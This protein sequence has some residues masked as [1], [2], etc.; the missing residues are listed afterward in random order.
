[1]KQMPGASV[2][3]RLIAKACIA[4]R[5]GNVINLPDYDCKLCSSTLCMLA[6]S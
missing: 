1:M 4:R 3:V 5:M 2:E 6:F